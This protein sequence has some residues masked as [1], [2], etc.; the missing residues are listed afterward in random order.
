L[1]QDDADDLVPFLDVRIIGSSLAA[2]FCAIGKRRV[3]LPR[4]HVVGKLWQRGDRGTLLIR[5]WVALDRR[6]A[7]PRPV[8]AVRLVGPPSVSRRR[9]PWCR[10]RPGNREAHRGD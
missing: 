5:R 4:L 1:T 2:L 8:V 7:I 3:W 9:S 6:L 10:P